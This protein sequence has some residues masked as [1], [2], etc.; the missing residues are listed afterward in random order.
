MLDTVLNLFFV[1]LV[2][3]FLADDAIYFARASGSLKQRLPA[4]GYSSALIASPR[5]VSSVSV[6]DQLGV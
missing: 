3:Y 6:W 1:G 5:F 4:Y 2:V